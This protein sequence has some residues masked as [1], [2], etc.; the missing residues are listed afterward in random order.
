[1]TSR[2]R[3]ILIV[4]LALAAAVSS[5]AW[6][7]WYFLIRG[8]LAGET[9]H[10]FGEVPLGDGLTRVEHTFNLTNRLSRPLNIVG[11]RPDCGC[12]T[13]ND[14]RLTLQ[15]GDSLNLPISLQAKIGERIAL[16]H[17]L[18]DDDT[19]AMLKVR[20]VGKPPPT[21]RLA[22][23]ADGATVTLGP[24]GTA[25]FG[26]ML[27]TYELY[28]APALPKITS[29]HPTLTAEFVQAA[30]TLQHRPKDVKYSPT[31]WEARVRVRIT[32]DA[33]M[34][35]GDAAITLEM[36]LAKPLLVQVRRQPATDAN[37]AT[38]PAPATSQD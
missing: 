27:D 38:A 33:A 17:V 37:A 25:E 23:L 24:D 2:S 18:F 28:D 30:W 6:A 36:P 12:L 8:P 26:I 3:I 1:M 9:Y 31:T 15:P 5:G 7:Y 29:S 32:G 4:A 35:P 20:A 34:L 10:D 14:M 13:V 16:I 22:N 11:I 19:Q 21:L